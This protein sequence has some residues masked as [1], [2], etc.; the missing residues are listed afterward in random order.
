M[1]KLRLRLVLREVVIV[2]SLDLALGSGGGIHGMGLG[3]CLLGG[4]RGAVLGL[5]GEGSFFECKI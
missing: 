5:V 1:G 4:G 3:S 2:Q